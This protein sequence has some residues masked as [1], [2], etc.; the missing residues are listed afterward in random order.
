MYFFIGLL[1]FHNILGLVFGFVIVELSFCQKIFRI[2]DSR[3][4]NEG[5]E[6]GYRYGRDRKSFNPDETPTCEMDIKTVKTDVMKKLF[7][8]S[9]ILCAWFSAGK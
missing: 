3:V 6:T 1:I 2:A 5:I 4:L 8:N 9:L 7:Y